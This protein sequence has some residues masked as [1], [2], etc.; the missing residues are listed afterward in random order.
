VPF[1]FQFVLSCW[2]EVR[3]STRE[4]G[5]T[6]RSTRH[7]RDGGHLPGAPE[8]PD[9][10]DPQFSRTFS[11]LY[12]A[13]L[14]ARTRTPTQPNTAAVLPRRHSRRAMRTSRNSSVH[15]RFVDEANTY[16][17]RVFGTAS[18]DETNDVVG[19]LAVQAIRSPNL[20]SRITVTDDSRKFKF[21]DVSTSA[22]VAQ[23][24]ET[25]SQRSTLK[26]TRSP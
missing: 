24:W 23:L 11:A 16:K 5:N 4:K 21:P 6:P 19:A 9:P 13:S 17:L 20:E 22:E 15:S 2:K 14:E 18:D 7:F 3:Q 26:D 8:T 1:G 12:F 25:R 10:V